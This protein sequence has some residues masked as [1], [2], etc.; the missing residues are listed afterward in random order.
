MHTEG[1]EIH[2]IR[3][4][5]NETGKNT[6][7]TPLLIYD[8]NDYCSGPGEYFSANAYQFIH[9]PCMRSDTAYDGGQN[10]ER[11]HRQHSDN[12]MTINT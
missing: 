2:R 5:H 6:A 10:K 9:S 3:G 12:T 7:L 8:K 1:E 11:V 4:T